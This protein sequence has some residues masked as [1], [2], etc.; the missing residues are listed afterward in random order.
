MS[1]RVMS[2][3]GLGWVG[4]GWIGILPFISHSLFPADVDALF[5]LQY[6]SET[7]TQIILKKNTK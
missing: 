4:L 2:W 3:D 6:N 7:H 5:V 1:C